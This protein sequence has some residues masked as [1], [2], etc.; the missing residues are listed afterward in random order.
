ME[1]ERKT[2]VNIPFMCTVTKDGLSRNLDVIE[3]TGYKNLE[4]D[5][6]NQCDIFLSKGKTFTPAKVKNKDVNAVLTFDVIFRCDKKQ[7]IKDIGDYFVNSSIDTV[8]I[9]DLATN[10][11]YKNVITK[12]DSTLRVNWNILPKEE[13]NSVIENATADIPA[14]FGKGNLELAEWWTQNVK[15]PTTAREQD[16]QGS[17]VVK[18]IIETD[19]SISDARILKSADPLLDEECLRVVNDLPRKW[20]PAIKNGK[21]C[22]VTLHCLLHSDYSNT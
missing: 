2:N 5:V 17:V 3:T 13:S 18:F 9:K 8:M 12:K 21:K 16:I 7:N 1:R 19:G 11:F 15:Y 10:I 6:K 20:T 4:N 22:G 14:S